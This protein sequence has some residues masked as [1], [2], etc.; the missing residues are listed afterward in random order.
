M[1]YYMYFLYTLTFLISKQG[2]IDRHGEY[3]ISFSNSAFSEV[4]ILENPFLW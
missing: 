4:A 3:K 1:P 2:K